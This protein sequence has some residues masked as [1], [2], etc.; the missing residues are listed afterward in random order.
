MKD[1]YQKLLRNYLIDWESFR[2]KCDKK[3]KDRCHLSRKNWKKLREWHFEQFL[4]TIDKPFGFLFKMRYW[5]ADIFN[6]IPSSYM[7]FHIYRKKREQ[8]FENQPAFIKTF[9]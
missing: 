9:K 5:N 4:G 8:S 1:E 7:Y 6:S 2:S 3:V